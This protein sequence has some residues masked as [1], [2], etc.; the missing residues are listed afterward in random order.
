MSKS[1]SEVHAEILAE[2]RTEL[3]AFKVEL[4]NAMDK[5]ADR[6]DYADTADTLEGKTPAQIQQLAIAE[7][8][9]HTQKLGVNAHNLDPRV[10]GSYSADEFDARLD[11]LADKN[12]TVPVSFL[13]D[14]EFLPPG[15]T[16]SFESGSQTTPYNGVAM[17]LEDNGTLMILRPGTDG[18]SA[19]VYYS[20]LRNAMAVT[21]IAANLNMTNVEYRPAYFPANMRAKAILT[22]TQDLIIGIMKNKDTG[23]ETGYFFSLTNNTMDYTKHTGIFVPKGNFLNVPAPTPGFVTRPFGFL[24]GDYVY[25]LH[26]L[27]TENN[28]L[29]HRVWRIPKADL[30]SGNFSGAT[31]ITGW[32]INRGTAGTVVRD[33]IVLFD[34][35][36]DAINMTGKPHTLVHPANGSDMPTSM[37]R[38]DGTMDIFFSMYVQYYPTDALTVIVGDHW[39]FTYPFDEVSKA[40]DVSRYWNTKVY[41][42]YPTTGIIAVAPGPARPGATTNSHFTR[43]PGQDTCSIIN[44]VYNQMWIWSTVTYLSSANALSRYQYPESVDPI[45]ALSGH[46][47]LVSVDSAVPMARFGSALTNTFQAGGVLDE[48]VVVC[49]NLDRV[50]GGVL[51]VWVRSAVEG[52]LTFQYS[53]VTG[54]YAFK[55][56]APTTDRKNHI[57]LGIP[58]TNLDLTLN[59]ASPGVLKVSQARF[60]SIWSN[61]RVRSADVDRN[62]IAT[63]SVEIAAGVLDSLKTQIIAN[64]QARGRTLLNVSEGTNIGFELIIPQAYTDL[65]PF[66][67]GVWADADRYSY[68][69]VYSVTF[70]G[71]RQNLT[72]ATIL[73]NSFAVARF[74]AVAGSLLYLSANAASGQHAIRRVSGGFQVA[75]SDLYISYLV[76]SGFSGMYLAR[77]ANGTWVINESDIAISYVG[78]T[79]PM[80]WMNFPNRGLFYGLSSEYVYGEIDCGTKMVG[81]LVATTTW[82]TSGASRYP[83]LAKSAATGVI[84]LSQ[85]VVSNWT[86]FF[87]DDTPAMIDGFYYVVEPI[88]FDLNPATDA[89]KTF[90]VWLVREGDALVYKIVDTITAAPT[91]N[92]LYLGRFT[93][94]NTGI[95]L[96][97]VQKRVVVGSAM[98]SQ[99]SRGSAMPVTSGTPNNPGRLNWR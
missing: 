89:N 53:S 73:P 16:G 7:V 59:E 87:S 35:V 55:G 17:I 46:A 72:A 6:A 54:N 88:N 41:S 63:G 78:T 65:P 23:A 51:P 45:T 22:G 92:A 26:D 58:S 47:N 15:V 60:A 2:L 33:D 39:F 80:S 76:G 12:S 52:D 81:T 1:S 71:T 8:E 99:T 49:I 94:T 40:V 70:S 61:S 83:A 98:V 38:D 68:H 31:R 30:I 42:N 13:G 10:L 62:C 91:G 43:L 48:D 85:R 24:K 44:T 37:G 19:G 74:N 90:H 66:V 57:Q 20:Y 9:K 28:Q 50:N 11:L 21:D 5:P 36:N 93:T 56:F 64:M 86:I 82:S 77:Y 27:R 29:G 95:N 96:I 32:T 14:R 69:F 67:V 75:I 18:D 97:D 34:H 84:L 3:N 4:L 25:V 79:A